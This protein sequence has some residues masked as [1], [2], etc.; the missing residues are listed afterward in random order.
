MLDISSRQQLQAL[1]LNPLNQLASLKLKQAGV[2]EDRAVLPIFCLMEWGLAGGRFCSTRRL[3]QELLRLRLMADQQAAVSYLLDNLPG[4]L[5]QLH[6]QLLRMSPK[7]AAEALLEV[8]DMRLRAD[9][10][11]PYPLS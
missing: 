10:R 4:G 11:N 9:P 6:R 7:G 1:R 8:L 2:A 5:P 3:P